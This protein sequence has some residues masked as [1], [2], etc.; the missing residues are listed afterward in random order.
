MKTPMN[1]PLIIHIKN[2]AE[3]MSVM[4]KIEATMP[5]AKWVSLDK[6]SN[7]HSWIVYKD[8]TCVRIWDDL[9]LSYGHVSFY[10]KDCPSTPII[11]AKDFLRG[12]KNQKPK[13]E[14][15][16][17]EIKRKAVKI[18][19]EDGQMMVTVSTDSIREVLRNQIPN[20]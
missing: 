17:N 8:N 9:F 5:E 16:L 3:W 11:S 19:I 1:L 15:I 7:V 2:E 10:Q 18:T 4:K 14:I 20:E 13:S 12:A 6:P